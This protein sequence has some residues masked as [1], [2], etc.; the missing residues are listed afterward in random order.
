MNEDYTPYDLLDEY[1]LDDE[2]FGFHAA[3]VAGI[4]AR[5]AARR[6]RADLDSAVECGIHDVYEQLGGLGERDGLILVGQA[7]AWVLIVQLRGW[8]CT[9]DQALSIA[10]SGGGRAVA[11]GW[12][13]D[14]DEQL[15]YAVDG[16]ILTYTD[17][18]PRPRRGGA[19]RHALDEYMEGLSFVD[20]IDAEETNIDTALTVIERITGRGIDQDWLEST[21]TG[22]V[23]PQGAW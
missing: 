9:R 1:G 14:G 7:G 6:M 3:W 22:Y 4:D 16:R 5:E 12:N 11:I 20:D 2:Y 8:D 23:I 19:D 18:S 21:H 15:I 10:S 13:A 17:F